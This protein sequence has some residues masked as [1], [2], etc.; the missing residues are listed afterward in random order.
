MMLAVVALTTPVAALGATEGRW[1][2]FAPQGPIDTQQRALSALHC[3]GIAD[4]GN[5]APV[6]DY[7]EGRGLANGKRTEVYVFDN[8]TLWVGDDPAAQP[9]FSSLAP[10][11]AKPPDTV[12]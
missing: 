7:W 5:L 11:C 1:V 3:D 10:G 2:P 8:G 4:V 12:G 6:G 9:K